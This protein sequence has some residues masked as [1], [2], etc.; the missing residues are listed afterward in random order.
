MKAKDFAFVLVAIVLI[1]LVALTPNSPISVLARDVLADS[2]PAPLAD[3]VG[4]AFTYQGQLMDGGE[5]ADGIYEFQ[6]TLYDA[7]TAGNPVGSPVSV[8]DVA[9]TSGLFTVELDFGASAF[10]GDARWLEIDVRPGGSP[11]AYTTLDLRQKITPTPY[12]LYSSS[13]DAIDGQHASAFA[14]SAHNHDHG[15]LTGLADDDHPQYFNLAQSETVSGI[16]AFNGGASGVSAPF[17]VDSTN[18]VTNLNADLLDGQ[19]ASAFAASGHTHWGGSWSGSGTGLSLGTSSGTGLSA[20]SSNGSS[21]YGRSTVGN[22]GFFENTNASND[23]STLYTK[24]NGAGWALHAENS[25]TTPNAGYFDGNVQITGSLTVDGP[26]IG[27]F[28]QPAWNSG[29]VALAPGEGRLVVHG[30]GGTRDNYVVD[31]QCRNP[32]GITNLFVGADSNEGDVWHGGYFYD[33]DSNSLIVSRLPDDSLCYEVR[34]RIWII[35]Y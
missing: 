28:P 6:F 12:A 4:T 26:A 30:L 7:D 13:A 8:E 24:T 11:G 21:V 2:R 19:H 16:P 27:F 33:L 29:W 10:A 31:F 23:W 1:V 22:S 32:W 9:V 15:T 5:P 14:A 20:L 35:D 17:S 34:V 25:N 3:P 18:T